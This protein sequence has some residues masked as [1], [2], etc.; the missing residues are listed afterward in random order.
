LCDL[1]PEGVQHL[2]VLVAAQP[3]VRDRKI[4]ILE[5]DFNEQ[6]DVVLS[7]GRI[8]ENTAA[9]C[10]LDQ[11]TFECEWSTVQKLASH[12]TARRIELFY[13]LGTGWIDRALSA[14]TTGQN[15]VAKW[16][17][18]DDWHRLKGMKKD[19]RAELFCQRFRDELGY[20]Y[21]NAWPIF[22]REGGG[23]VMYHM[24]HCTDHPAALQLMARAY[25][26]ATSAFEP[27]EQLAFEFGQL[28]AAIDDES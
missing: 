21:A 2:K 8:K 28:A 16:W 11:R 12:K 4:A 25:R 10:L 1:N 9:F 23:A 14:V 24:I 26:R 19:P 27:Q 18:R 3:K 20:T 5:G 17:G 15:Q 22:G 6:V 7:S 13:F